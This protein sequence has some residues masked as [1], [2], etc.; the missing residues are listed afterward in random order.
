ML[1]T[2]LMPSR[3]LSCPIISYPLLSY[4]VSLTNILIISLYNQTAS[5]R[6]SLPYTADSAATAFTSVSFQ[7]FLSSWKLGIQAAHTYH[8]S[9]SNS[10]SNNRC[11]SPYTSQS[12][13]RRSTSSQQRTE[14][15]SFTEIDTETVSD[16]NIHIFLPLYLK[17]RHFNLWNLD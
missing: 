3:S 9:K 14:E 10:R 6:K 11:A 4:T 2:E 12:L 13:G 7:S 5:R 8:S 16:S 1:L 15:S 17:R